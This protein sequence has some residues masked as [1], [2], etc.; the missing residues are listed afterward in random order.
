MS[1]FAATLISAGWNLSVGAAR[2][3]EK[4][5]DFHLIGRG[6]DSHAPRR[7][8]LALV[9]EGDAT[10]AAAREAAHLAGRMFAEGYYGALET[11]S[12][13]RA[14]ARALASAN[15][16]VFR[17]G[18][19]APKKRGMA[20]SLAAVLC[21]ASRRILI[22]HLGANR[23]YLRRD[24]A[25]ELLTRAHLR[26]LASGDAALTR[27]VGLDAEAQAEVAEIEAR[28]DDR[29]ALISAALVDGLSEAALAKRLAREGDAESAAEGL[30]EGREQGTV[31]VLD[32]VAPPASRLDDLAAD[33]ARLPVKP[34]PR[35]GE[36][37]DGF[38]V[39]R[40]LYRGRY[41]LLKRARDV[42]EE[43]DVVLKLPLPAL[44]QDPVFQAGFLRE[45]WIGAK[46]RSRWTVEYFDLS[47]ER[48]SALYLVMP[49]YRGATLDE[50]LNRPPPVSLAE[51]VGV[52]LSLC[53]AIAD[54]AQR[55]VVHRDIKPENVFLLDS[56]EV[57]LLDL[58]LAALPGI[59]DP[60]A[61]A[62]GGTTRY[63]A[64]ELFRGAPA[65]ERTEVFSLGVTLYRLFTGDFPFGR[66]EPYPLAR[67]RPDLPPWLGAVLARA[68]EMEPSARYANAGALR[69]A[70]AYGL[71][72]EDWRGPPLRR[73][74]WRR[75][76]WPATAALLALA[77]LS[78][79]V[80]LGRR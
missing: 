54:L 61:D 51:G 7:G 40:T 64:P 57:K 33:F 4:G 78:L 55:Q 56:G 70:L 69:E 11:L 39:G 3:S 2:A 60:E 58:G 18:R 23:V 45:A 19:S 71:A 74:D 79:I 10:G 12:P 30:V 43:R 41:T 17:E 6:E 1:S 8:L 47:P 5:A 26:P 34:P 38:L 42:L 15:D 37:F 59:D 44:T 36:L 68:L 50:R 66:R 13:A 20:A 35:E 21:P 29:I 62:L 76:L 67:V 73:R 77:C 48:R 28:A 46:L 80:I 65:S 75:A 14:A 27:G 31:V 9:A 52:G 32:V 53:D 25:T 72:H 49:F 16:W 22:L 24:G 63:M